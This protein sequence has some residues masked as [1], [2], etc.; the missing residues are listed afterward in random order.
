MGNRTIIVDSSYIG[1]KALWSFGGLEFK[2]SPTGVI[3][4]FLKQIET[5]QN[6]YPG[7]FV[8]AFD[9]RTS[10]RQGKLP[11]YKGQR[12]NRKAEPTQ[13]EIDIQVNYHRQMGIL[14]T[15]ILPCCGFQV[16]YKEGYEADDL[17]ASITKNNDDEMIVVSNDEDLFQLLRSNVS[18][19]RH[20]PPLYT[21]EDFVKEWGLKPSQWAR[22]KAIA[23]CN[24]DNIPGVAGVG[25][26]TAA[27]WL[28][29]LLKGKKA[30]AIAGNWELVK[31]NY[32]LVKL[33]LEGTGKILVQH[34]PVDERAWNDAAV[35]YG[36]K[37]LVRGVKK[38]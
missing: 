8:F 11:E 35:K 31:R 37:S 26:A 24:S 20:K 21:K 23:G 6:G 22:V 29:G 16:E 2:G 34:L 15:K 25:N 5:I 14:R 32:P 17:I 36:M 33:P 27:K 12:S 19:L 1:H 7:T 10:I 9:S 30:D 18:L 28:R 4:G 13:E 38:R 3:F